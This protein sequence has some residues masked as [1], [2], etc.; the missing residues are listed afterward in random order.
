MDQLFEAKG[1]NSRVITAT[2]LSMHYG[3]V[4]A[5]YRATFTVERGE[6]VVLLGPMA[7]ASRRP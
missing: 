7:P 5:L 4:I 2:N 3:P 1:S 6:V